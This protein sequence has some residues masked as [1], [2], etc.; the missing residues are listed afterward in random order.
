MELLTEPVQRGSYI[1]G[2]VDGCDG[3]N[4]F[5][6][7]LRREGQ[8]FAIKNRWLRTKSKPAVK[9][10]EDSNDYKL[11]QQILTGEDTDKSA[12]GEGIV[13]VDVMISFLFL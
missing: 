13:V 2:Y 7:H 8:Q 1:Q 10:D 9:S 6:E 12:K 5:M 4:R 3:L 11:N